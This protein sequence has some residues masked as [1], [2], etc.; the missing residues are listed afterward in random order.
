MSP[1]QRSTEKHQ[2]CMALTGPIFTSDCWADYV[3]GAQRIGFVWK[4]RAASQDPGPPFSRLG[5]WAAGCA[6]QGLWNTKAGT[7][8]RLVDPE[9]KCR[10]WKGGLVWFFSKGRS[11]GS[12]PAW[13]MTL[14][15]FH[16][17]RCVFAV[18]V[19]VG[20]FNF[21]L[22]LLLL[23]IYFSWSY[24]FRASCIGSLSTLVD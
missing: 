12:P 7:G 10:V 23:F 1:R 15:P 24:S 13:I 6:N 14:E 22:W 3:A 16:A 9:E 19:L 5:Q 2:E 21:I 11:G 8:N 20:C 18:T 17:T 4:W